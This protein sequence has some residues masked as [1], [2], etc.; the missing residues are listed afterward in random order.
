MNRKSEI[1]GGPAEGGGVP[2]EGVQ[3]RGFLGHRGVGGGPGG[4][5][6]RTG[7]TLMKPILGELVLG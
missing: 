7:A 2:R 4:R 5:E 1:L 6:R 3:G